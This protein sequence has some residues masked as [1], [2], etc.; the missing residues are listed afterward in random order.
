MSLLEALVGTYK[1]SKNKDLKRLLNGEILKDDLFHYANKSKEYINYKILLFD[2]IV[3]TKPNK[4]YF[5]VPFIKDYKFN[6]NKD[7]IYNRLIE[8][9]VKYEIR[10]F[11]NSQSEYFDFNLNDVILKIQQDHKN[12][13]ITRYSGFY[14]ELLNKYNLTNG[15]LSEFL[16]QVN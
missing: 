7:E 16:D 6:P 11:I 15:K 5:I 1:N 12:N 9:E 2:V 14:Y 8:I 13:I 3:F 4:N 10:M